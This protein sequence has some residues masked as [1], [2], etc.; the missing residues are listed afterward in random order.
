MISEGAIL[1]YCLGTTVPGFNVP[2]N[3]VTVTLP[4]PVTIDDNVTSSSGVCES[5]YSDSYTLTFECNISDEVAMLQ[6]IAK[7]INASNLKQMRAHFKWLAKYH[8][9]MC[10]LKSGFRHKN[11]WHRTR[12]RCWVSSSATNP[13]VVLAIVLVII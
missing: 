1:Y 2:D 8:T 13:I 11:P 4:D 12:S 9:S 3:N 5:E 10:K 6:S 7:A